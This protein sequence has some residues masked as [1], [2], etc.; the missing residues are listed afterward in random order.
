[1]IKPGGTKMFDVKKMG[2][3][4]AHLRA[5]GGDALQNIRIV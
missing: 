5:G 3:Q 1:M 2:A 4:I